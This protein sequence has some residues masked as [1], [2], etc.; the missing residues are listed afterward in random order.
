[1][2]NFVECLGH[3]EVDRSN[4]QAIFYRRRHC[5]YHSLKKEVD[6]YKNPQVEKL[7]NF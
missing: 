1:M 5:E 3:I 2:P 6:L 7:T 4:L